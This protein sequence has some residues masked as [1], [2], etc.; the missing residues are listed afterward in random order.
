MNFYLLLRWYLC[1]DCSMLA[2]VFRVMYAYDCSKNVFIC[3]TLIDYLVHW[4][5]GSYYY[6]RNEPQPSN[7][8]SQ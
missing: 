1:L 6:R 3:Q 5:H 8:Q 7:W 2:T 4:N